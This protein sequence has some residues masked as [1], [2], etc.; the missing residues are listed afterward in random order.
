MFGRAADLGFHS[1]AGDEN[2]TAT[3]SL[4]IRQ[5]GAP[6][7]PDLGTRP[8]ASDRDGPHDTRANGPSMARSL[9]A[10]GTGQNSNHLGPASSRT[11]CTLLPQCAFPSRPPRLSIGT[12]RTGGLSDPGDRVV[13]CAD[14]GGQ[15][16]SGTYCAFARPPR[17]PIQSAP[18]ALSQC[19]VRDL[20][21]YR[22]GTPYR[23]GAPASTAVATLALLTCRTDACSTASRRTVSPAA[24][25]CTS[26]RGSSVHLVP[27]DAEDENCDQ[28]HQPG[29]ADYEA[30]RGKPG[31]GL[32]AAADLAAGDVA[33]RDRA[34]QRDRED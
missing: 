22:A 1:G 28:H 14:V 34:H 7:R 33:E 23:A 6:D 9:I 3:I 15:R 8:T 17:P 24:A 11:S 16:L 29:P 10:L 30:G 4:G 32:S 21:Q 18:R 31:P 26:V 25:G 13:T 27:G 20:R 2:R 5:I 12:R 19:S